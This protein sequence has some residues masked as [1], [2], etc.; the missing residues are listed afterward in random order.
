MR[1]SRLIIGILLLVFFASS[2]IIRVALPW[3]Q[4]FDDP[5]IK[6]TSVDGYYYMRLVDNA[7]HNFPQYTGYDPYHIFPEGGVIEH[8]G[9]FYQVLAGFIWLIGLGHPGQHLVDVMGTLFAPLLAALTIIPVFFIGKLLFNRWVGLV[10]AA[11]MAVLP[12]EYLGRSILG[13]ADTP[14]VETFLTATGIAFLL[15]AIKSAAAR[16]LTL[17]HLLKLEKGVFLRPVILSALAGFFLGVYMA[18]WAGALLFV[19][20]ITLYLVVQFVID[21]LRGSPDAHSTEYLGIVGLVL[22][23]VSGI[24]FLPGSEAGYVSV[25]AVIAILIPAALTALSRYLAGRG[26]RPAYY[27]LAIIGLAV[28]MVVIL[29]AALPDTFRLIVSAFRIFAPIGATATTTMEMQPFLFP[30]P[31]IGFTTAVAW[32]NF[33]TSFF[34]FPPDG[35]GILRIVPGFGLITLFILMWIGTRQPEGSPQRV[36]LRAANLLMLAMSVILFIISSSISSLAILIIGIVIFTLFFISSIWL[37]SRPGMSGNGAFFFFVIWTVIILV[38]TLVQRRFAYYLVVNVAL[39]SA[40]L[41]WEAVWW[42]GLRKL[43]AKAPA[44]PE[45]KKARRHPKRQAGPGTAGYT[46]ITVVTAVVV[47]LVVFLPNMVKA[48][49]VASAPA[50]LPSDAWEESLTWMKNNTPEP[51]GDPDAYYGL[52]QEGYN[53]PASAYGVTSWWDYGYWI[54][55]IAHRIPSA[56]PSQDPDPIQ[57]VAGLLLASDSSRVAGAMAELRSSY[58]VGDYAM[59]TSKFWAFVTWAEKDL[60]LYRPTYFIQQ[61]NNILP[62][63]VFSPEYYRTLWVR[64]YNFD[65]K[66][67][68][69][70]RPIVIKYSAQ[71]DR[72]GVSYRLITESQQFDDYQAA[73]DYVQ[74]QGPDT[75]TIIGNNAFISPVPLEAVPDFS[76]VYKSANSLSIQD[77]GSI[78]EVKVFEYTG[79]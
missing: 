76:P 61:E 78:S 2:L 11:L 51:L 18:T 10:A 56:N 54:T 71:T 8:L 53:Y 49:Q 31:D 68:T 41:S 6:E 13:F 37:L 22:F 52:Y 42:F 5:W 4:V 44:V 1:S 27:P 38:L 39:L 73:L 12:G 67:V 23:L 30:D 45:D 55:R 16:R 7:V 59:S 77:V 70:P 17:D 62:V 25:A 79:P 28:V 21:H 65:G 9:L 3:D 48:N 20:I 43:Q 47:F 29:W 64:L 15:A 36:A 46:A 75:H 32:G 14:V 33:T 40:W 57:V 35:W 26:L 58:V 66:A 24:I 50:F 72:N 19:F 60:E 74:A 69:A 63:Q 34:L